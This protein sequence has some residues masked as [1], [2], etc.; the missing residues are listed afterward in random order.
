MKITNFKTRHGYT[1]KQLTL[2]FGLSIVWGADEFETFC[3]WIG[4]Q[5]GGFFFGKDHA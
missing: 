2:P 3:V 4:T 1:K 5:D